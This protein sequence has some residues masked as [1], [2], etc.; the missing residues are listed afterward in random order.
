MRATLAILTIP[1]LTEHIDEQ[2]ITHISLMGKL[3][4]AEAMDDYG[5]S[6]HEETIIT[7]LADGEKATVSKAKT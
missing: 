5:A 3:S 7:M 6:G 1:L 2:H 4:R